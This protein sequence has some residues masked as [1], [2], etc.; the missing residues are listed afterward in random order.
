M[1]QKVPLCDIPI[2]LRSSFCALHDQTDNEIM[3]MG[4]CPYDQGGYFIVNGSEKVIIAQEKMANNHVYV[5]EKTRGE[6]KSKYAFQCECRSQADER[7]QAARGCIIKML[8]RPRTISA[9]IPHVASEIPIMVIFRALGVTS[10]RDLFSMII[11]DYLDQPVKDAMTELLT[12]SCMEC[13][14]SISRETAIEYIGKKCDKFALPA[15]G[16]AEYVEY[17][18]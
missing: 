2:M 3:G 14:L 13:K 11:P 1:I 6:I 8:K 4:E 9:L 17:V 7:F 15:K 5:F 18:Y 10:Q 16:R 12:D